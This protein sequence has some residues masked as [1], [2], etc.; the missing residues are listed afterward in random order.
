LDY[1]LLGMYT[2]FT[3][4]PLLILFILVS[5]NGFQIPVFMDDMCM[6]CYVLVTPISGDICGVR[7]LSHFYF[8]TPL[9]C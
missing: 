9:V 6:F 2:K 1:K 8:D 7:Y 5:A 3:F 4:V